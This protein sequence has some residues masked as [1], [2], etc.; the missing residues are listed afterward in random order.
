MTWVLL[1][2]AVLLLAGWGLRQASS[3]TA[4]F[5]ASRVAGPLLAGL[6]GT[7]AGLSAFVFVGGPGLFATVGVAS[8][9]IILS[10]PLTGALQC[11]AVGEPI[12]DLVRRNGC[13]T[14]PDLLAARFGEG[15][16]RGVAAAAVAVGGV[17]TLAVQVKG[18]EVVGSTLLGSPGWLVAGGTVLAT[19]TYT[20]AGGMRAGLLAEAAQGVVMVGAALTLAVA[21]LA[22]AGGPGR[23]LAT[24]AEHRPELLDPWNAVGV[25]GGLGWFLLF[26]LGTCAQPH[27]LQKFLLLRDRRSLRWLPLVLTVALLAVLTVWVGLGLGGTALWLDGR[28]T[29]ATPDRLAP[30]LLQVVAQPWLVSV[31]AAGILAAVMSTAA[32]LLNL[33]AAAVTRD[34]PRALGLAVGE[35]LVPARLATVAAA[36]LAAALALAADRPVALLG[37]LGWGAFTAAFLPVMVVGLNWPGCTRGAAVAAMLGGAGV[38][39]ALEGARAVGLAVARWEPGLTG[40][41]IGTVV[42]VALSLGPGA[43]TNPGTGSGGG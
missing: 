41:A 14:V 6:A 11:W 1:A 30:A 4:Y 24:I 15:W 2:V 21:S 35:S 22:R 19:V 26:A 31:A 33:V 27:Y 34:L 25:T 16:P 42:L 10:A 5:A 38:Q 17:A 13:L 37:V 9:W 8:L 12:V 20:A 7:A 40:A 39:L 32:S 23:A 29:L 18:L 43:T 3:A 28:L 36:I